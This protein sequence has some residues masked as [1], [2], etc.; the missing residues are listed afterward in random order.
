[1]DVYAKL[2]EMGLEIMDHTPQG[3]IYNSVRS[4]GENLVYVSG[5][6]PSCKVGLDVHG[7]LGAELSL[8]EGQE[9]ARRCMMNILS[10][11]HHDIGDLNKIKRFVKILAFVASKDDFYMQ[12]QVVNGASALLKEVFGEEIGLPA[13]SAIGVNVLPGNIPVEI[14]VLLELKD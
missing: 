6:G 8:E 12:P 5:T 7:K 4:F 10:N 13:R 2:R 9:Q 3:G 14:E 11:L 1:M